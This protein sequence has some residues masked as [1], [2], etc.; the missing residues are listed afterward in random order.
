[1]NPRIQVEHT[2][3]EM[4]TGIILLM[5]IAVTFISVRVQTLRGVPNAAKVT[6]ASLFM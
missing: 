6:T 1:M 5:F 2:C 4:I 3:S